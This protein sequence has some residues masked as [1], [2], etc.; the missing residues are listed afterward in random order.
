MG[1]FPR[2]INRVTAA[3]IV[4]VLAGIALIVASVVTATTRVYLVVV[5]PV[6]VGASLGFLVGVALLILG[7]IGIALGGA[8]RPENGSPE[9]SDSGTA[10]EAGSAR[11]G[12]LVLIG[13]IPIF[14]G[15][16]RQIG[17]WYYWVALG[18]GIVLFTAV[19]ALVYFG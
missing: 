3:G 10:P 4:A 11:T 19:L 13:P 6:L 12:G 16:A 18:A 2:M 15:D 7:F 5:I 14:F 9:P 17:D 8:V 1:V